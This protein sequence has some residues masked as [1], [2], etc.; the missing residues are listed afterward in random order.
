MR[1]ILAK[2]IAICA[3]ATFVLQ[4]YDPAVALENAYRYQTIDNAGISNSIVTG[5]PILRGS[6][7]RWSY[8]RVLVQRIINGNVYYAEIGWVKGDY[9]ESGGIPRVYW[10]YRATDGT[11]SQGWN[12]YVG[13]GIG[14]NYAV[15][16]SPTFNYWSFYFNNLGT[17]LETRFVG[18]GTADRIGSGGEVIDS[19]Q[20]M[21]ISD[22]NFTKIIDTDGFEY[23]VSC[24]ADN[25]ITD[26]KY[27]V[28][29]KPNDCSSWTVHGNNT[30]VF[31]PFVFVP[32]AV[33]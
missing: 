15:R 7:F 11:I 22:N 19:S 25:F 23:Y 8:M 30:D 20:G 16:K 18:W 31:V 32:F 21:G 3:V 13:V 10:T 24:I 2:T 1:Q 12:G 4:V 27:K 29:L 17:P 28:I 26:P 9:P 6:G 14:Y 33:K 5:N